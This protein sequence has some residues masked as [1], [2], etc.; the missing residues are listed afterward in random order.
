M[1]PRLRW[2][3]FLT[4][5]LVFAGCNLS[6]DIPAAGEPCPHQ[7]GDLRRGF[8]CVDGVWVEDGASDLD[9]GTD[10]SDPDLPDANEPDPD[11]CQP[12]TCADLGLECGD[13]GDDGCGSTIQ[14]GGCGIGTCNE[15][16]QCDCDGESSVELCDLLDADCGDVTVVDSCERERTINCG[17]CTA[18]QT[19]GVVEDNR[20]DCNPFEC[21][22][23]PADCGTHPD[24]CGSTIQC[25]ACSSS[26][27]CGLVDGSYQ[28]VDNCEPY[29]TCTAAGVDCGQAADGCGQILEC[30][31]CSG[32]E[33]TCN[34]QNL[35]E[36][37]P[38][39]DAQLCADAGAVCG[40]LV[41][42]DNCGTLRT[43]NN[44]GG[45]SGTNVWVEDGSPYLC[46]QN[47][48]SC[49]CQDEV[50]EGPAC[51]NNACTYAPTGTTRT[52]QTNCTDCSAFDECL[53]EDCVP[54]QECSYSGTRIETCFVGSCVAGSC[55][56]QENSTEQSCYENTDGDPCGSTEDHSCLNEECFCTGE[57][58]ASLCQ[59]HLYTCGHH[60]FHNSCNEEVSGYCG[61]CDSDEICDASYNCCSD[62]GGGPILCVQ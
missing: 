59:M 22:D 13:H 20:C 18:P 25:G 54:D 26:L 23:I 35:C 38:R 3:L 31:T 62:D 5:L 6:D 43:V 37:V 55:S 16:Y 34:S 11:V 12:T 61:Q 29:E 48:H 24:G 53:E 27:S 46:C 42:T 52:V 4:A 17:A 9:A 7:E 56:H 28:C 50:Q 51:V 45:C 2:S 60:T 21:S 41:V 30:G 47:S 1:F 14:C 32:D 39:S 49:T 10:T 40:S 58:L 15:D 57:S 36:C 44:C 33:Q 19:C 8:R